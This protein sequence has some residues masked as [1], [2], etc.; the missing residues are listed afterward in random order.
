MGN[1]TFNRVS[2]LSIKGISDSVKFLLKAD[3]KKLSAL[4]TH[5]NL[6]DDSTCKT[7]IQFYLIFCKLDKY[8]HDYSECFGT[9]SFIEYMFVLFSKSH[10]QRCHIVDTL[11]VELT[12]I[13]FGQT[14]IPRFYRFQIFL[15]QRRF[16]GYFILILD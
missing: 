13:I 15:T 10:T 5:R 11:T 4:S 9:K 6:G 14:E 12:I 3:F 7:I 16:F 8:N 1:N 2:F